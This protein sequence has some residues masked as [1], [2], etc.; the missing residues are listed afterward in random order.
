MN[1]ISNNINNSGA[2]FNGNVSMGNI[3]NQ[4]VSDIGNI[5]WDEIN[6]ELE[7]LQMVKS[8]L[9]SEMQYVTDELT[10]AAKGKNQSLFKSIC[11][12]IGQ[13]TLPL[14]E[15]LGLKLITGLIK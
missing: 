12:K 9:S 6:K 5:D 11:K 3:G 13:S 10:D 1:S 7:T 8:S 4:T 15:S 2:I 14:I